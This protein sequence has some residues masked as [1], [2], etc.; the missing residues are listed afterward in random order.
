MSSGAAQPAARNIRRRPPSGA[1]QP[2]AHEIPG[3]TPRPTQGYFK[4]TYKYKGKEYPYSREDQF[5]LEDAYLEGESRVVITHKK[6][7]EGPHE[8]TIDLIEFT[9]TNSVIPS[10]HKVYRY[11][12]DRSWDNVYRYTASALVARPKLL[13]HRGAAASSVEQTTSYE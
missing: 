2:T 3:G 5:M 13:R 6:E 12:A 9:Q 4:W 10:W 8:F 7:A 1:A 11:T